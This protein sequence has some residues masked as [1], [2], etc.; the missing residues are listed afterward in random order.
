MII[1]WEIITGFLA[2]WGISYLLFRKYY[3]KKKGLSKK[4][5]ILFFTAMFVLF[6]IMGIVGFL[7]GRNS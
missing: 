7:A 1:Q 5:F 6:V 4:G 2:I 3:D